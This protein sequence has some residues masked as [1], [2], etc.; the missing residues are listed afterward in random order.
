MAEEPPTKALAPGT[1]C[2]ARMR[3]TVSYACLVSYRYRDEPRAAIMPKC[4]H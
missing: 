3:L 4:P 2:T 1:G